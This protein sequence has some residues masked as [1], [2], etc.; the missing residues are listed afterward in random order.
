MASD[1]ASA[2][3]RSRLAAARLPFWILNLV[4]VLVILALDVLTTAGV[5]VGIFL[6]LPIILTSVSDDRRVVWATFLVATIGFVLAAVFGRGPVAPPEVWVPNRVMAFITL[7]A[8]CAVALLLQRQRLETERARDAAV[9]ASEMSRLLM[10]LVAHDVRSPLAMCVQALQYV[11]HSSQSGETLDRA[12][13]ADVQARLGRN[14]GAL[15]TLLALTREE[16]SGDGTSAD[17]AVVL[18]IDVAAE[19]T[20][21]VSAFEP[22]ARMHGKRLQLDARSVAGDTVMLHARVLKQ[23]FA[24]LLDNAVRHATPGTISVAAVRDG[25]AI[26]VSIADE[27]PGQAPRETLQRVGGSGIGLALCEAVVRRAGGRVEREGTASG[28]TLFRLRLPIVSAQHLP[29][30]GNGGI[31]RK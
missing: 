7:P 20:A 24:I 5:V 22:E 2:G 30:S 26:V 3:E 31:E 18:P 11:E 29:R 8:S 1:G 6:S 12:L 4:A 14:L 27:G 16:L 28:G 10:S 21:E 13:L 19:L 25:A 23:T 9:G 15:D 17:A